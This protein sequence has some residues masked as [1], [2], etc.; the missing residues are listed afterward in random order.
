MMAK[1]WEPFLIS[2]MAGGLV[3][4]FEEYVPEIVEKITTAK[5]KLSSHDPIKIAYWGPKRSRKIDGA[6][7]DDRNSKILADRLSL[8]LRVKLQPL[9]P[10]PRVIWL[11]NLVDPNNRP[12]IAGESLARRLHSHSAEHERTL[13][14]VGKTIFILK[15]ILREKPDIIVVNR[16]EAR[17]FAKELEIPAERIFKTGVN[18]MKQRL[19]GKWREAKRGYKHG[20]VRRRDWLQSRVR[21]NVEQAK[22]GKAKPFSKTGLLRRTRK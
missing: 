9:A 18:E 17:F 22:S 10:K 8:D 15:Q 13:R 21:Q 12:K 20:L 3:G 11:G 1:K 19:G 16:Q 6:V 7:F 14:L 2:V 4:L 5:S